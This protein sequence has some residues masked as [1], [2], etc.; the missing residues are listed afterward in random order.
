M[1][2]LSAA[3]FVEPLKA[4]GTFLYAI[5]RLV[6]DGVVWLVGFVPQF[7][8]FVLKLTTQ[9][10]FLQGYAAAMVFGIVVILLL[11]LL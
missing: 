10:G 9:R 3:L 5:D 4:L 7:S 6:V 8:G 2:Q 1:D 11:V